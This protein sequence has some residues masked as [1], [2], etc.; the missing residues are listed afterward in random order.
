MNTQAVPQVH[1]RF[2]MLRLALRGNGAFSLVSGLILAVG[3]RPIA[4]FMGA[5]STAV[6]LILGIALIIFGLDL[7][8]VAAKD[9][10]DRRLAWTAVI[11]D[12]IW[13][14]AS[15][16]LLLGGW[17]SLAP[18]GNWT[19]ALLAEAVAVFAIWQ[20]IGLRRS[21]AGS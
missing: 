2:K 8:W 14:V 17:L 9:V 16:T 1:D 19:I 3:A 11:L 7:F 15:Y 12:I 10:I 20:I 13:V 18:A 5:G 6:Y 21:R 4:L